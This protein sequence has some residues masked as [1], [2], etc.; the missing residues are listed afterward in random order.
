MSVLS[1]LWIF[2]N[3]QNLNFDYRKHFIILF[4]LKFEI[5]LKLKD[6]KKWNLSVIYIFEIYHWF[7]LL[8][9]ISFKDNNTL[10]IVKEFI[11]LNKSKLFLT[12]IFKNEVY[13]LIYFSLCNFIRN[14]LT[15]ENLNLKNWTLVNHIWK[16][17]AIH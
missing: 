5:T 6:T 9:C 16:K 2:S 4:Y 8:K 10:F 11:I 3:E 15:K 7:V 17:F 12:G 13:H 1:I 14:I